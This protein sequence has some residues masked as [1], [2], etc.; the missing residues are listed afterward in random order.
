MQIMRKN[1][2]LLLEK[3]DI[4]YWDLEDVFLWLK[5]LNI[6]VSL[7]LIKSKKINGTS[8]LNYDFSE[9]VKVL[10]ISQEKD[11]DILKRS[12]DILKRFPKKKSSN[13]LISLR[14]KETEDFQFSQ[15]NYSNKKVPVIK[16]NEEFRSEDSKKQQEEN[17]KI[18]ANKTHVIQN[19]HSLKIIF[20][21]DKSEKVDLNKMH[22]IQA[23]KIKEN[24]LL[25]EEIINQELDKKNRL[26]NQ[27]R[28]NNVDE[29]D[30][31]S[32]IYLN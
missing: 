6:K 20:E 17:G 3:P 11:V 30:S 13:M 1:N 28:D 14:G 32:I 27:N 22:S 10:E 19:N 5:Q 21:E 7:D 16:E 31:N 12:I 8:L 23:Q 9:L 25:I 24:N 15:K 2:S 29:F 26:N 18:E 4:N